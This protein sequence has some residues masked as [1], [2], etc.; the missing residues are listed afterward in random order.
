VEVRLKNGEKLIG[1]VELVGAN[2]VHLSAL[3]GQEFF[4]AAV[5]LTDI[6]AVVVRTGG[7]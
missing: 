3:T 1:K 5:A 2:V 4:D 7:K 6:S